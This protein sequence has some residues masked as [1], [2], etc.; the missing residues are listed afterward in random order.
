MFLVLLTS[1]NCY[2]STLCLIHY[3]HRMLKIHDT[4]ARLVAFTPSF[5]LDPSFGIHSHK[6]IDTAQHCHPLKPNWKPSSSH[7]IFAPTNISTQ[8]L[9][10]LFVCVCVCAR[11][12]VCYRS[13]SCTFEFIVVFCVCVGGGGG[14]VCLSIC[15][16]QVVL[17]G[18]LCVCIKYI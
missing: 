5:A 17:M 3:A 4:N 15:F 14:I 6:T 12:H 16:V 18:L 7:S 9:L 1:L 13:L 2:M 10:Q 8:F 11:A